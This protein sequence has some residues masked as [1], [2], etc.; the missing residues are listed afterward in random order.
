[1]RITISDNGWLLRSAPA[2]ARRLRLFCFAHAGGN[3]TAFRE[4]TRLAEGGIEVCAV[5]YPGHGHRIREPLIQDFETLLAR[6]AEALT[7]E[8]DEPYAFFGH[9]LGALL[10]FELARQRSRRGQTEPQA[11][12]VSGHNGP[13]WP[14]TLQAVWQLSDGELLGLLRRMQYTPEALL[15][16]RELMDLMLP[17]L[18]AD[19]ALYDS[20]ASWPGAP[21]RA[22]LHVLAGRDDPHT[23]LAG[24][25]AWRHHTDGPFDIH[26]FP[27][28]HFYL[29]ANEQLV[30]AEVERIVNGDFV[31]ERA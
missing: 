6:T 11:L 20:Y 1:M 29:F 12:I 25:E 7:A 5:Q 10:A 4:W 22:A 16:N 28:D 3:A 19:F 8:W 24:L 21:L 26:W 15:G 23:E 14:R 9:S 2:A 31:E 27:G 17:V 18:R 13:T 30:I